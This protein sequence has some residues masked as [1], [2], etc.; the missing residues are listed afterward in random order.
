VGIRGDVINASVVN[1][2]KESW[3]EDR[4]IK[5]LVGGFT[6]HTRRHDMPDVLRNANPEAEGFSGIRRE[7]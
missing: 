6:P 1:T 5:D 4:A 7:R 2:R 3:S